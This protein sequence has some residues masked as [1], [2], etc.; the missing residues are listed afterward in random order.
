MSIPIC[1]WYYNELLDNWTLKVTND[2]KETKDEYKYFRVISN[3]D[4]IFYMSSNDY[5][6]HNKKSILLDSY[7]DDEN[8]IVKYISDVN[9]KMYFVN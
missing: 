8:N 1:V 5:L 3:N 7:T 4:K 2:Y 9:N 6:K